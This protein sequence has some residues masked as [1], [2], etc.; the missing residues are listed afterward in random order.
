MPAFACGA[1]VQRGSVGGAFTPDGR[2]KPDAY[3]VLM[4]VDARR[5][6]DLTAFQAGAHASFL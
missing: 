3:T 4:A 6:D 2:T 5:T 1:D